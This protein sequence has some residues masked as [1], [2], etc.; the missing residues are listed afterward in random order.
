MAGY[1]WEEYDA[2]TGGRQTIHDVGNRVDIT[3]EFV[4]IPS[5]P[6]GG[7]WGARISGKPREDAPNV[8]TTVVFA[9]NME[10][11]GD[12]QFENEHDPR[13]YTGDISFRGQTQ[14]LGLFNLE[15]TK[16]PPTNRHPFVEHPSA[17]IQPLDRTIVNS[18]KVPPENAWQTKRMCSTWFE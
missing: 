12:L 4:K 7:N 9:A 6:N 18:V 2:R 13:G 14:D 1:G 11:L 5:G 8:R 10:G 16:G 17:V 3:T 15:I